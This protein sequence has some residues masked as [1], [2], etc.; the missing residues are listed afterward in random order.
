M[1]YVHTNIITDNWKKLVEFYTKVFECT[2]VPPIRDLKGKWLEDGTAVV[3]AH[4]QGAHLRLP[5]YGD[6][7]PTLEIF[8]Y[9]KNEDNPLS[10]ANRKGFGHIAFEVDDI[11][12]IVEKVCSNGGKALGEIVK[13][14][15]EGAGLLSFI[16]V[17]DPDGNIIELQNWK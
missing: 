8:Q 1:K 5:G 3:N 10:T 17:R 9:H 16:Y 14:E 4:L 7:G 13:K 2:L 12:L 11:A 6:N 15:V